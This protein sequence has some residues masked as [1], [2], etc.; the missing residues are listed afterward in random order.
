MLTKRGLSAILI[1]V[2]FLTAGFSLISY[3]LSVLGIFLLSS[4]TASFPLFKLSSTLSKIEVERKINRKKVFAY[5]YV[6]VKVIVVNKGRQTVDYLEIYDIYPEAFNLVLGTNHLITRLDPGKKFVFSYILFPRLRGEYQIG[7]CKL[8]VQD[9]LRFFSMVRTIK[10]ITEIVVYPPYEDIK[11]MEIMAKKRVLGTLF[12]L[13]R[14]REKGIGTEFVSLRKYNIGDEYRRIDWKATARMQ[15]LMIREFE[16]EKNMKILILLDASYSMAAGPIEANKL[17]FAIR[18]AAILAKYALER[19]DE[20]GLCVFSNEIHDFIEPK[21]SERH[22]YKILDALARVTLQGGTNFLKAIDTTVKKLRKK[23]YLLIIS[24]LEDVGSRVLD[25]IKFARARGYDILIISP[26]GPWFEI[27]E[28]GLSP[29]D[30][31]LAEATSIELWEERREIIRNIKRLDVD[32]ITVG[33]DDIIP[34]LISEYIKAK[35]RG[36]AQF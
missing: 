26:F 22:F 32:V 16:T 35:K 3:F 14:T 9:K 23:A 4:V 18:A 31:A 27:G 7:P 15:R 25:A 10:T 24:D 8:V 12:G 6:Y 34:T 17:E 11:R 5:D 29:V 19:K 1:G 13:H 30:K 20:V 33:P 2:F 21:S 36:I 28:R